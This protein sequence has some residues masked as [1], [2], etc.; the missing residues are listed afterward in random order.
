MNSLTFT[1]TGRGGKKPISV[2]LP[3]SASTEELYKQV[4]AKTR[5]GIIQDLSLLDIDPRAWMPA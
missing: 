2:S 3:P 1:V 5:V 4:A